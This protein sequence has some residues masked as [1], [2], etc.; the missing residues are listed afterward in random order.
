MF[1]FKRSKNIIVS[2]IGKK[3]A[4][5][6]NVLPREFKMFGK[7]GFVNVNEIFGFEFIMPLIHSSGFGWTIIN[8]LLRDH[9]T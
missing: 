1:V 3:S 9:V 4:L 7:L 2:V 6:D 8:E 5:F